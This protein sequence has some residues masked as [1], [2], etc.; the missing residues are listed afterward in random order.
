MPDLNDEAGFQGSNAMAHVL[1]Q[2]CDFDASPPRE[3]FRTPGTPPREKVARYLY[4]TLASAGWQPWFQNFTGD[5][6]AKLDQGSVKTFTSKCSTADR[7]RMLGLTFSNVGADLGTGGSLHILLAHY[8]SK[9]YATKERDPANQTRPVLGANDGASGVAVWLEAARVFAATTRED[10][11]RILFVD[12]EDGFEDCHPLAGSIYYARTLSDSD[13]SRLEG[14]YLLD[15][16]GDRDP[17]FCFAG[18]AEELAERL[19]DAARNESVF[20]VSEAPACFIQD[21]HTAFAD[22][23]LPAIDLIDFDSTRPGGFPIYWHTTR[24]TPD[25][26]S[27]ETMGSVGRVVVA[28]FS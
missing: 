13:R 16:V 7:E 2:V 18:D 4:D 20:T 24:D 11:L 15:M 19:R 6:Y 10:T 17:H 22:V 28:A 5:D 25:K 26:L 14:V 3:Q 9:R 8:D 1:R 27:A 21:D 12:G 23:G